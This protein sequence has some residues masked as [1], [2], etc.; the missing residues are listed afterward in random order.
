[1]TMVLLDAAGVIE[2]E[3]AQGTTQRDVA[4][5]YRLAMESA[6]HGETPDWKRINTAIL[7]RWSP[8][9]LKRVKE[10]AWSG[11]CFAKK[12]G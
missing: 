10:L 9:G 11:K 6:N 7:K 4:Q 12:E 3:I 8:A 1:M 2:S 5:T